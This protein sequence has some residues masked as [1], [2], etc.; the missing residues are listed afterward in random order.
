[1]PAPPLTWKRDEGTDVH[2][3]RDGP[4]SKRLVDALDLAA[5]QAASVAFV[6]NL[7][8]DVGDHGV[9]LTA[10]VGVVKARTHPIPPPPKLPFPRVRNF[11][12]TAVFD[13]GAGHASET[14]IRVHV[15]DSVEAIWLTPSTLSIHQGADES[16]FTVLA[17]FGDDGCV[18]DITDWPGLSFQSADESVVEVLGDGRLRA[19]VPDGSTSV[20]ATLTLPS[21]PTSRTSGPATVLAKPP[22][23]Q[24]AAAA[25]VDFVAG[26]VVPN[27]AD[28]DSAK[29]DSVKSVVEGARNILFIA[30][31]FQDDQRFDYRNIVNTIARVLRGEEAAFAAAFQPLNL[32]KDTINFWTV[33]L[34]SRQSGITALGEYLMGPGPNGM[35]FLPQSRPAADAEEWDYLEFIHEVGLPAPG[36]PP[37]RPVGPRHRLAAA[38]RPPRHQGPRRRGLPG[39]LDVHGV[40]YSAQRT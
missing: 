33:F 35:A 24:V 40:P 16:R 7:L 14:E 21:P 15:H 32:L 22:W 10:D 28:P 39:Q 3:L 25:R 34:P 6:P 30:D 29:P 17:R 11:L 1:M 13:D 8:G 2:L 36:G 18:G 20:T 27:R 5:G 19:V 9:E 38:V 37:P 12:L 26:R 23:V 4:E 31:G